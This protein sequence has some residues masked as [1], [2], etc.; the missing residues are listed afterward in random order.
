MKRPDTPMSL[1]SR[2]WCWRWQGRRLLGR[3]LW[4]SKPS[5]TEQDGN[6][7][8]GW[9][10][11]R[12]VHE[13]AGLH[14]VCCTFEP[15]LMERMSPWTPHAVQ[16]RKKNDVPFDHLQTVP[17]AN[18]GHNIVWRIVPMQEYDSSTD[19]DSDRGVEWWTLAASAI[20]PWWCGPSLLSVCIMPIQHVCKL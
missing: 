7:V 2:K 17:T 9:F 13:K 19:S 16:E 6:S 14:Y 20:W 5:A 4:I 3:R 10:H 8:F 11:S 15:T 12:S 18:A 1:D